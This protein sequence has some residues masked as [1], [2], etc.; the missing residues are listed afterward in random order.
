MLLEHALRLLGF[1]LGAG[2]YGF[3]SVA[4]ARRWQAGTGSRLALGALAAAGLWQGAAAA[5]LFH[6]ASTGNQTG[7]LAAALA[8]VAT[9]G[10][11]LAPPLALLLAAHWVGLAGRAAAPAAA[12]IP[13]GWWA[14]EVGRA[15]VFAVCASLCWAASAALSLL[16]ARRGTAGHPRFLRLVALAWAAPAVGT[17]AGAGSPAVAL[18]SLAPAGCFAYLV[19]RYHFLGLLISRRVVFAVTLGAV[20]A[21]YL[22]AVRRLAGFVEDEFLDVFGAL[23]EVALILAAA[24]IWLPLYGWMNRFLSKQT[25]LYA[26]F[27]KRLIE[28]AAR[29]L[30]LGQ[31]VQFLAE[32]VGRTFALRRVLLIT[33]AGGACPGRFGPSEHDHPAGW[34]KL[35]QLLALAREGRGE[36]IRASD[37][38]EAAPRLAALGFQY[39]LPLR[40]EDHL[41]GLL[42]LDLSPR[43]YLDENEP[44]LLGLARQISHSL[45]TCRVID[46]KIGLERALVRQEHLATL[47][48][49]AATIAHEIKNPL[50]SI[51]T[52][53]QLMREDREVEARYSRD[54]GYIVGEVDRLNQSVQQLLHFSRPAPEPEG[55]VNLSELLETTAGVLARQYAGEQI[56]IER[57][58]EPGLKLKLASR[59]QVQQVVLNL[60]LNAV[61]ACGPRATVRLE[62]GR[63]PD[64]RIRLAV[65]D[66]GP[67]IPAELREKIFE[68]FFTTK[69]KGTGLGL[70]IVRKNVRQLGGEIRIESPAADGRGTSITVSLPE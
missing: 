6:G 12:A 27:S 43:L 1:S 16:A 9:A 17:L 52:L 13:L 41:T 38:Q 28:E 61:Q 34:E 67:G 39:L 62:A 21:V 7:L 4:A 70:S 30:D 37:A 53:T 2:L 3:L 35:R 22:F 48:Q 57:R 40:Y 33:S 50:S 60:T 45:E 19:Y 15:P 51:K 24:L 64:G 32:E 26:D 54:L 46:E 58:I 66:E 11:A 18:A 59:E 63:G 56:R 10:Q 44:I 20:C 14:L 29:I 47:G 49:V 23:I 5:A 69:Q 8:Q 68:P 36:L 42:L 31:R 25:Q 55:E 65:T